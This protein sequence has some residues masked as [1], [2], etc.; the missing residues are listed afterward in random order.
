VLLKNILGGKP[1]QIGKSVSEIGGV[2]QNLLAMNHPAASCE[3]SLWWNS[4][5]YRSKLRGI[6]RAEI[7]K[8]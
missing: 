2:A 8:A 5:S 3:V 1:V 7:K 6:R 4:S